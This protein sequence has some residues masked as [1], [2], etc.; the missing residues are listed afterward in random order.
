MKTIKQLLITIAV[1]LCSMV[2]N[3]DSF[4]FEINGIYYRCYTSS[5][6]AYVT[7]PE[8]GY[9]YSGSI[10]IPSTIS[11]SG[12]VYSV[13]YIEDDAFKD[14]SGLTSISIPGS[15][16]FIGR[17]AFSGCSGLTSITI[18]ESV[19]NVDSDAF[20]DC[21]SL[22]TLFIEDGEQ[23]IEIGFRVF[24]GCPLETIYLGRNPDFFYNYNYDDI[25]DVGDDIFPFYDIRTLKTLTMGRNVIGIFKKMFYYC[26][27]LESI[28]MTSIPP[29]VAEDSFSNA[30]YYGATL[31]VPK[32]TLAFYQSADVWKNFW[33]I[34]EYEP[35]AIEDIDANI[36]NFTITSNGISLSNANNSTVAIYSINGVLVKKIDKY[37]GEEIALE[38]GVYIVCV[39]DKA[40]KIIL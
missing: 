1:L 40:M 16:A 19:K 9:K 6:D 24:Q 13:T 4:V 14:C 12:E 8:Y 39:G 28:Y 21:T 18:P 32:G 30:N 5:Q 20:H 33:N 34:Q 37:T 3:A 23:T 36:P 15:V 26:N 29:S 27:N 11:Y 22:R 7:Y 10:V 2:A 17:S 35:T 38:K 31:Y 25:D